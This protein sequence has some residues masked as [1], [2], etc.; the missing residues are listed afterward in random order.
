[1]YINDS[2]FNV[3]VKWKGSI[4]I[5]M[6]NT[7]KNFAVEYAIEYAFT[8]CSIYLLLFSTFLFQILFIIWDVTIIG[9]IEE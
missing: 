4:L 9:S 6:N 2:P 8:F 3:S 7:L 5:D 1:M